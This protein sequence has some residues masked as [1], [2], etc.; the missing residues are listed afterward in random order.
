MLKVLEPLF[1]GE[2]AVLAEGLTVD[3][4]DAVVVPGRR[5]V[6]PQFLRTCLA[7]YEQQFPGAEP[8]ALASIWSKEYFLTLLP[9]VVAASLALQWQ[10]PVNLDELGIIVDAEGLPSRM[11]LPNEGAPWP[12]GPA[13]KRFE[14]LL[15][16][17]LQP[18]V[19]ALAGVVKLAPRVL[20]NN[21]GNYLETVVHVLEERGFAAD[22]L[23][24][25]ET[26]L[27]Q[28]SW[29]D[30]RRN[31][32]HEPVRYVE[33]TGPHGPMRI[34]QRRQCCL[35]DKLPG[36]EH[37]SDCPLISDELLLQYAVEAAHIE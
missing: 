21:A 19:M 13:R 36:Y 26:W 12:G 18:F 37:C 28:R 14:T 16:D 7:T 11:V 15:E 2:Y 10:L 35:R 22:V 30:G 17:N 29:P 9:A 20:W 5:F 4:G 25:G 27:T 8:R 24:D 34:R 31:P 33:L 6:E 23:A 1:S 32:L 3:A